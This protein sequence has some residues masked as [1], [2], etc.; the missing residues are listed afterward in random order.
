MWQVA[1]KPEHIVMLE[2]W[3][4]CHQSVFNNFFKVKIPSRSEWSKG[5]LIEGYDVKILTDSS[6]MSCGVG[7]G[8]FSDDLAISLSFRL[9]YDCCMFQVKMYA[10]YRACS[11]LNEKSIC[12]NIRIFR[13][14]L[15]SQHKED[16]N[17]TLCNDPNQELRICN[18]KIHSCFST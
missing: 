17:E 14:L 3:A 4:F 16:L 13:S 1:W 12:S 2:S 15:V 6:K 7:S 11:L 18:S 5:N 8:I 9:P 10:I